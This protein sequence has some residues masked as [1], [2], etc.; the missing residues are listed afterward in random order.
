MRFQ[1]RH[2][3]L[4]DFFI[5]W[6]YP[7]KLMKRVKELV[8]K[9]KSIFEVAAGYG[10]MADYIDSSSRYS[11]IDLNPFFLNYAKKKARNVTRGD[12]FNPASYY[13]SDVI[14]LVDGVHHIEKDRLRVLF[15]LIFTHA[16][17]RVVVVEPAFV[18]FGSRYGAPGR[19]LDKFLLWF[20]NDGFNRINRWFTDE[21]YSQLFQSRFGSALGKSFAVQHEKIANHHVVVFW[22]TPTPGTAGT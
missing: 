12:M 2:P 21:E 10:R 19:I 9:D 17:E 8:G 7:P 18:N 5:A 4:Y 1:Y 13:R 6:I 16:Q 22:T 3:R 20:D 14:L 11:G 15:D